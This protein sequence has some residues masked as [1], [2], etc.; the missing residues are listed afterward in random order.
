MSVLRAQVLLTEGEKTVAG[1]GNCREAAGGVHQDVAAGWRRGGRNNPAAEQVAAAAQMTRTP[2]ANFPAR[3]TTQKSSAVHMAR[4]C[5]RVDLTSATVHEAVQVP[6][7]AY[8]C[9]T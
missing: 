9:R 4:A 1:A 2:E 6:H 3:T 5:R 7:S 8:K